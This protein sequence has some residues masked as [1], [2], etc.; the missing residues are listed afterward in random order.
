[1]PPVCV[2]RKGMENNGATFVIDSN[3]MQY[4]LASMGITS[5]NVPVENDIASANMPSLEG[6]AALENGRERKTLLHHQLVVVPVVVGIISVA[7]MLM[8]S[9]IVCGNDYHNENK[10]VFSV[11]DNDNDSGPKTLASLLNI[12]HTLLHLFPDLF[13]QRKEKSSSRRDAILSLVPSLIGGGAKKREGT[14]ARGASAAPPDVHLIYIADAYI[15]KPSLFGRRRDSASSNV[16]SSRNSYSFFCWRRDADAENAIMLLQ[17]CQTY[18][19]SRWTGGCRGR[20]KSSSSSSE[21]FLED[22]ISGKVVKK[23]SVLTSLAYGQEPW[24]NPVAQFLAS[25]EGKVPEDWHLHEFH[26]AVL[27]VCED[28]ER[29]SSSMQNIFRADDMLVPSRICGL[30]RSPKRAL[31]IG[32]ILRLA[33]LVEDSAAGDL[34]LQDYSSVF[35]Q[36]SEQ[37]L[38]LILDEMSDGSMLP[39]F[40]RDE[41]LLQ[42]VAKKSA[43]AVTVSAVVLLSR[44]LVGMLMDQCK[45]RQGLKCG[46]CPAEMMTN[47]TSAKGNDERIC[48]FVK[49][50]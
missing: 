38:L 22:V 41:S 28:T 19:Y 34:P 12:S 13:L 6:A 31:T 30:A 9:T 21:I 46:N 8:M 44:H 24:R 23:V 39:M 11:D 17:Q 48:M 25:V 16:S 15:R 32:G 36:N 26:E 35:E 47:M 5:A 43:N 1:M 2:C 27:K 3:S 18:H 50:G 29:S 10:G 42:Q 45:R 4:V 40:A 33:R 7:V 20:H 37:N 14:E 49:S